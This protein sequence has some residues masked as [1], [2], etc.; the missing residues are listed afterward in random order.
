MN[1]DPEYSCTLIPQK[2]HLL[3][4]EF[5]CVVAYD[6]RSVLDGIGA[7]RSASAFARIGARAFTIGLFAWQGFSWGLPF[8]APRGIYGRSRP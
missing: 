6:S 3:R 1:P 4:A 2:P 8:E 5:M 7:V